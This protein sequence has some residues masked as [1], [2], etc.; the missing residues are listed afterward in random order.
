METIQ[1]CVK[2]L[3]KIIDIIPFFKL[4]G[5][6]IIPFI[7]AYLNI[8]INQLLHKESENILKCIFFSA[9]FNYITWSVQ[10]ELLFTQSRKMNDILLLRL[11]LSKLYCGV[12]IPGI[13]QKQYN[14]LI[15]NCHKLRDFLFVIPILYSTIVNFCFN[16]YMMNTH[17][18]IP[19]RTIYT[20]LCIIMALFLTWLTDTSLYEKMKPSNKLVVNFDDSQFV[21]TKMSMGCV[22]DIDYEKNRQIKIHNQHK[23]KQYTNIGLNLITTY[24]SLLHKNIGQL[25][26]FSNITWMIGCLS[27]NIK[28]L[29]YY[30][31]MNTFISFIKCMEK[32]KLEC[33]IDAKTIKKIQKITFCNA[34]FGYYSDD[35]MKNPTQIIKIKNLSFTF[36]SGN[37]YY[38]EAQNGIGKSTILKMFLSNL[39]SGEIYFGDINRKNLSFTEIYNCVFHMVQASEYTPKF[40][41]DEIKNFKGKDIWLEKRFL[42][43]ELFEKD[44]V[45][46]SGG[47]KKRMLLYILLTSKTPVLLLDEILSELSTEDIPEIPEGGGWLYRVINTIIEWKKRK[48]KIIIL[49]GHGL[50]NIIY[51][52]KSVIQLSLEN[53]AEKTILSI[54]K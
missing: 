24:I 30:D 54:K 17:T 23:Y 46:M 2:C 38:L 21:K 29:Q 6:A 26:S 40:S 28:S 13:N 34:S 5:F 4:F 11:K 3:I 43:S 39:F 16:I 14:E 15:E 31:Y 44:T 50:Q 19:L 1:G 9:L 12:S 25:H 42:L 35:L 48:N 47:Q 37:L 22:I 36:I 49:V 41:K 7:S 32:Y 8:Y 18:K 27:N 52:K 33:D 20:F 10:E 53:N 45:E 51:S